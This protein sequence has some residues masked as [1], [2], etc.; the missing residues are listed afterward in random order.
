[1]SLILE[2]DEKTEKSLELDEGSSEQNNRF[3]EHLFLINFKHI[4]LDIYNDNETS[5]TSVDS[6]F[7]KAIDEEIQRREKTYQFTSVVPQNIQ[8]MEVNNAPLENLKNP[9][10][11]YFTGNKNITSK[12]DDFLKRKIDHKPTITE[13]LKNSKINLF[14]KDSKTNSKPNISKKTIK[15]DKFGVNKNNFDLFPF[16]SMKKEGKEI[17]KN[18]KNNEKIPESKEDDFSKLFTK[19]TAST[20]KIENTEASVSVSQNNLINDKEKEKEEFSNNNYK[21]KEKIK[22][23]KFHFY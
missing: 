7:L 22:K 5:T 6:K 2:E 21:N 19:E 18:E 11:N 8:K 15:N 9:L 1:M 13:N 4:D 14:D 16:L 12:F 17:S 23:C 20:K 3:G 10:S